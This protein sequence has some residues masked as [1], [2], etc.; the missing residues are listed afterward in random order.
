M[1]RTLLQEIAHQI[2][3]TPQKHKRSD[4]RKPRDRSYEREMYKLKQ[5]AFE[6]KKAY[7]IAKLRAK[8]KGWI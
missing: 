4:D 3:F 8:S 6:N 2:F 1:A 5:A 7:E